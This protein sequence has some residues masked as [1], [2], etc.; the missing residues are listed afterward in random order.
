[1]RVISLPCAH[2]KSRVRACK[3]RPVTA[4]YKEITYMCQNPDCGHV[5]VACLEVLRTISLSAM[6]DAEV[7][8]P[9]SRHA[10]TAAKNQLALDLVAA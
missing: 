8:I 5:F 6:P 1:M 10:Q 3:S 2:C 7:R 4:T 9:L